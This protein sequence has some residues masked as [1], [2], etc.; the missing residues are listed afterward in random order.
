MRTAGYTGETEVTGVSLLAATF[1]VHK[2]HDSVRVELF[3]PF[4]SF[5]VTFERDI[6]VK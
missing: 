3:T 5:V 2:V 4:L 1:A 6:V